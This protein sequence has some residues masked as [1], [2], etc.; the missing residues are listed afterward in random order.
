MVAHGFSSCSFIKE[1]IRSNMDFRNIEEG[2]ADGEEKP[3]FHYSREERIKNAPEIVRKYYSGEFGQKRGFFRVLVA[4]K[5][6]RMIFFCLAAAII[7]TGFMGFFGPS[8]DSSLVSGV[9]VKLSAFSVEDTIYVS[10]KLDEPVKK[11]REKYKDGA[12]KV[13]AVFDAYDADSQR[14]FSKEISEIYEG[15]EM[16]LRT[17]F[18][19]YDIFNI[20]ADVK[21]GEETK[22]LSCQVEKH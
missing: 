12:A 22:R 8:K 13:L 16:F 10:L 17:T 2:H 1:L 6:N 5:A 11:A 4:T 14:L 15:R 3:V 7:V 19:D 9:P 20:N 18:R 21:I